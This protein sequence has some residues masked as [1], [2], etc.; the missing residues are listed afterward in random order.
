MDKIDVVKQV[1]DEFV[2]EGLNLYKLH[3]TKPGIA[4]KIE[5]MNGE[6]GEKIDSINEDADTLA[7]IKANWNSVGSPLK[8]N[9]TKVDEYIG[10][11]ETAYTNIAKSIP[12]LARLIKKYQAEVNKR[13]DM[14]EK[15]E[16]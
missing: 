12:E 13:E 14:I 1:I 8:Y 16:D 3:G 15:E 10:K 6:I 5:K 7:N 4:K 11:L 9:S 2:Q